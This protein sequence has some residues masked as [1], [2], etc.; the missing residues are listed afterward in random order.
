MSDGF[1]KLSA[2]DNAVIAAVMSMSENMGKLATKVEGFGEGQK[3]VRDLLMNIV[4]QQTKIE[5]QMQQ[6]SMMHLQLKGEFDEHKK[7]ITENK[8][9]IDK[10]VERVQRL[11]SIVCGLPEAPGLQQL[12]PIAKLQAEKVYHLLYGNDNDKDDDGILSD[13][14]IIIKEREKKNTI[15]SLVGAIWTF[16][17]GGGFILVAAVVKWLLFKDMGDI[18]GG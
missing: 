15:F 18:N 11:E 3:E 12:F 8:T 14:R 9:A 10:T 17:I 5:L 13:L 2:G 4:E 7:T 6:S 16:L 1:S